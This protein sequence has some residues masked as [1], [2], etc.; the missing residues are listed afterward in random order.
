MQ[1]VVV[2][3]VVL[4]LQNL[5]EQLRVL[6]D[7]LALLR[8]DCISNLFAGADMTSW[9]PEKLLKAIQ[10]NSGLNKIT[11]TGCMQE[12]GKT[13]SLGRYLYQRARICDYASY[14]NITI[15]H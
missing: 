12:E 10:S 9:V 11:V 7:G 3:N 8:Y 2:A 13:W 5:R 15:Q 4:K 14:M 6:V 1:T